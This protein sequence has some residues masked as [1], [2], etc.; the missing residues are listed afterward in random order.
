MVGISPSGMVTFVYSGSISDKDLTR[1]SCILVLLQGGDSVMADRG[2]N[3][4]D[5]LVLLGLKLN[6]P[7]F[8][9][10]KSQL[11]TNEMIETRRIASVHIE[12][13]HI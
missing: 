3:I 1:R 6:M 5:D 7:P 13:S 11:D 2:F 12:L 9:K 8:L 4:Q 10:G